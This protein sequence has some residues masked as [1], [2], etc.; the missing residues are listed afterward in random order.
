M[1]AV[2]AE[3]ALMRTA[4]FATGKAAAAMSMRVY[5][6]YPG[7]WA[8]PAVTPTV[9]NSPL[10]TK[11]TV[12]ESVNRYVTRVTRLSPHPTRSTADGLRAG[13]GARTGV[14]RTGC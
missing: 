1:A 11:F 5:S 4:A 7:A 13:C 14:A 3:I 8:T 2:I 6:G 12:G 10:S 9:I